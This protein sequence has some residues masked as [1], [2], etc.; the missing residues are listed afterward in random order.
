LIGG[1]PCTEGAPSSHAV[2]SFGPWMLATRVV[3]FL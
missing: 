3:G 1:S 2:R